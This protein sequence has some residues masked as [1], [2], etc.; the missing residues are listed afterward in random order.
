MIIHDFVPHTH[1]HKRERVKN[2]NDNRMVMNVKSNKTRCQQENEKS[3]Q[4]EFMLLLG[5]A[6]KNTRGKSEMAHS[7]Y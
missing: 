2:K 5:A 1:N 6:E 3:Y 4:I 7:Y